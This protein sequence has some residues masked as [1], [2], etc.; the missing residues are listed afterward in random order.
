MNFLHYAQRYSVISNVPLVLDLKTCLILIV[1]ILKIDCMKVNLY[2]LPRK[3]WRV[4]CLKMQQENAS[5]SLLPV[6]SGSISEGQVHKSLSSNFLQQDLNNKNESLDASV[7]VATTSSLEV[8]ADASKS[9]EKVTAPPT[10]QTLL[11]K[12]KTKFFTK[13]FYNVVVGGGR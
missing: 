13:E 6:S 10:Q 1:L 3:K 7:V 2:S 4:F 9:Q 11:Q 5:T 12:L 8:A